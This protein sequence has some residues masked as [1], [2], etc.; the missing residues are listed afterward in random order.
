VLSLPRKPAVVAICLAVAALH[1]VTGPD[2]GGP[3]RPFVTGYLMDL[4]LPFA[5]V[6]LLGVGAESLRVLRPVWR[7]AGL[8]FGVGVVVELCQYWGVP[9]FGRTFDALDFVMYAFGVGGAVGWEGVWG[10]GETH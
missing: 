4:L 9:V 1:L 5:M 10:L 3:F 2:Y 7:R 8:V 6:L